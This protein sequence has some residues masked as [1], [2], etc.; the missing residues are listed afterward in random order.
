MPI[1][2]QT[3]I[4]LQIA[5]AGNPP[6]IAIDTN[7]GN[8]PK[9]WRASSVGIAIGIFDASGAPV[10]L[11]NLVLGGLQLALY[12]TQADF[13]PL[14]SKGLAGSDIYPLI[15]TEGWQDGTQQ[16]ATFILS[17]GDTDQSLGA[18]PSADFWLVVNGITQ[19]GAVIVYA[20]GPCTIYNA[21]NQL[22]P[23]TLP[24]P[25]F[26]AQTLNSGNTTITPESNLHTEV[27]TITGAPRTSNV[28]VTQA[29]L[30]A[31]ALVTVLLIVNGSVPG[32]TLEFF[33]GSTMGANPFSFS[34]DGGTTRA[35]FRFYFDGAVLQPLEAINPAY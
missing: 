3:P 32:V 2:E 25:S 13:L 5:L 26:N 21:A 12:K 34:T 11:T 16:N 4:R 10:D 18:E 19:S 1:Y 6:V 22:P 8:T 31:G 30:S 23:S 24:T 17:P 9:F 14:I 20:A 28:I 35:M 33:I 15:T 27:I 29:G 7:T